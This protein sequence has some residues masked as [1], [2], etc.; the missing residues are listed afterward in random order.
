MNKISC[1]F[2]GRRLLGKRRQLMGLLLAVASPLA[3]AVPPPTGPQTS[4]DAGTIL[5]QAQPVTPPPTPPAGTGLTIEQESGSSL[6]QTAP[7]LVQSIQIF[8]NTRFDTP[9]LHALLADAEGQTLTLRQLHERVALITRYYQAHGYPLARAIIPQQ[10]IQSGNVRIE[11]IEA[12][13]GKILLQNTSRVQD[14]L[15]QSTLASLQP[16]QAV[17]QGFL[18]HALLLL[19][20]VPGVSVNATLKPGEAVGTSDLMVDT[21]PL[22]AVAGDIS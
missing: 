16:G 15:L 19:S 5:Q 6:P 10:L 20:D 4:P 2:R 13:Y 9:T 17:S 18:D 8:G 21:K 11:I 14:P 22:P 1:R 12:H 7:F 3:F